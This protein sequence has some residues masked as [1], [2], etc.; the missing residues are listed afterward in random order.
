M[1]GKMSNSKKLANKYELTGIFNCYSIVGTCGFSS[2]GNSTSV[3]RGIPV[4]I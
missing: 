1:F 2:M 4:F 3:S